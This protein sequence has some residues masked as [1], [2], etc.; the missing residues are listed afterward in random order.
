MDIVEH[1]V[2]YRLANFNEPS[3]SQTVRFTEKTSDGRFIPG[4]TNE[5]VIDM[6]IDRMYALNKKNFSAENQCVIILLKSIRQIF[7]KR[8]SKKVEK[9]IKYQ[10]ENS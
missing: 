7:K 9:V 1:G 2:E 3:G 6:M 5:E 8:L 4:T 10:E